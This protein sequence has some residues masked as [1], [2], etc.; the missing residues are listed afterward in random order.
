MV[1]SMSGD[2]VCDDELPP[3]RTYWPKFRSIELE[4]GTLS[5]DRHLRRRHPRDDGLPAW[6]TV[7]LFSSSKDRRLDNSAGQA[8][9]CATSISA[10]QFSQRGANPPLPPSPSP[11]P[12]SSSSSS[13]SVQQFMSIRVSCRRQDGSGMIDLGRSRSSMSSS[14]NRSSHDR[15]DSTAGLCAPNGDKRRGGHITVSTESFLCA[16]GTEWQ[17]GRRRGQMDAANAICWPTNKERQTVTTVFA[18]DDVGT[19]TTSRVRV[20]LDGK[21]IF[22]SGERKDGPHSLRQSLRKVRL[23]KRVRV[24]IDHG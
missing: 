3:N 14:S 19:R 2:G 23:E 4:N 22:F 18:H 7:A 9:P 1:G 5:M 12:L 13:S 21:V 15:L 17:K 20:T 16:N 24:I 6:R 11:S 10:S 8:R